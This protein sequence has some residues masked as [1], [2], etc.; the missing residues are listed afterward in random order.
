MGINL[1]NNSVVIV[2]NYDTDQYSNGSF[3]MFGMTGAGK[4]FT[5]LLFALRLRMRGVL[6][7]IVAPEKGFE[8]RTAC[9]AIGG[10]YLRIAPGSD[11]VSYTHLD[12][13][14]RQR[15]ASPSRN[16]GLSTAE[17]GRAKPQPPMAEIGVIIIDVY[18]RQGQNRLAIGHRCVVQ[19][20]AKGI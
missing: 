7:F 1:H 4:T 8:Y 18:K 3:A 19:T 12:V 14:K 6:V 9:E 16:A 17:G 15:C 10:Q 13:Y 5:T 20:E 2:D 11:A